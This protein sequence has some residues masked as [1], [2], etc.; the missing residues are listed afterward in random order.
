MAIPA[1]DQPASPIAQNTIPESP[2]PTKRFWKLPNLKFPL[3]FAGGAVIAI[4][5]GIVLAFLLP[6]QKPTPPSQ[7]T[8]TLVSDASKL[9][10]KNLGSANGQI[11]T[12]YPKEKKILIKSLN[13]RRDGSTKYWTVKIAKDTILAN[14]GD[15]GKSDSKPRA[16]LIPLAFVPFQTDK[17][18]R[19]PFEKL[20]V[21]DIVYLSIKQGQDLATMDEIDGP[22]AILLEHSS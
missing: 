21:G 2:T 14:F 20:K 6:S 16:G 8:P 12:I 10:E 11:M 7:P 15:W 5:A 1:Q 22:G 19:I 17:V 3:L 18:P 4:V 13:P 9:P